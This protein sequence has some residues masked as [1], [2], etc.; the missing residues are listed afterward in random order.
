VKRL[1]DKVLIVLGHAI[2]VVPSVVF[3]LHSFWRWRT[4]LYR[5][6]FLAGV[7]LAG[8]MSFAHL[9]FN[10]FRWVPT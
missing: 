6:S 1:L 4:H 9:L 5:A 7:S 10:E 8:L 3:A 2:V